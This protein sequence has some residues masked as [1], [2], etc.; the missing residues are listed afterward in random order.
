MASGTNTAQSATSSRRA[1]GLGLALPAVVWMAGHAVPTLYDYA[2]LGIVHRLVLPTLGLAL[3]G[4]GALSWVRQDRAG[5]FRATL[6]F[7]LGLICSTLLVFNLWYFSPYCLAL[8]VTMLLWRVRWLGWSTA[9]RTARLTVL[10]TALALGGLAWDWRGWR[11]ELDNRFGFGLPPLGDLVTMLFLLL[12]L[13]F[14]L[15]LWRQRLVLYSDLFNR[16]LLEHMIERDPRCTLYFDAVRALTRCHHPA[17]REPVAG[18]SRL[19]S[20][21]AT[22]SPEYDSVWQYLRRFLKGLLRAI[23]DRAKQ[24]WVRIYRGPQAAA[25]TAAESAAPAVPPIIDQGWDLALA[26]LRSKTVVRIARLCRTPTANL[27]LPSG[28][29][30]DL[31]QET[32]KRHCLDYWSALDAGVAV[33]GPADGNAAAAAAAAPGPA[34]GNAAAGRLAAWERVNEHFGDMVLLYEARV[35]ATDYFFVAPSSLAR[36]VDWAERV[37]ELEAGMP[38]VVRGPR[39]A[40]TKVAAAQALQAKG[41]ADGAVAPGGAAAPWP[42]TAVDGM[43]RSA[44]LAVWRCAYESYLDLWLENTDRL[45]VGLGAGMFSDPDALADPVSFAQLTCNLLTCRGELRSLGDPALQTIHSRAADLALWC[46]VGQTSQPALDKKEDEKRQAPGRLLER[47]FALLRPRLEADDPQ[48]APLPAPAAAGA[49]TAKPVQRPSN[50]DRQGRAEV[51]GIDKNSPAEWSELDVAGSAYALWQA[52]RGNWTAAFRPVLFLGPA[53]LEKAPAHALRRTANHV[54][55]LRALL[56][57]ASGD[58]D[59]T[60]PDSIQLDD[61]LGLGG[62]V[63]LEAAFAAYLTPAAQCVYAPEDGKPLDAMRSFGWHTGRG[64]V[65]GRRMADR[66]LERLP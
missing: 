11:P 65:M 57:L 37:G 28:V 47:Y 26:M 50:R 10:T 5:V 16:A 35:E 45:A 31:I 56:I 59:A 2:V 53:V 54:R 60:P 15:W 25:P 24:L 49:A 62:Q 34:D 3:L 39:S 21:V 41:P 48:S 30:A 52:A 38:S 17:A 42:A 40:S 58:G 18:L 66:A 33:P 61:D 29:V 36:A 64:T 44:R 46:L 1:L 43:A 4:A 13:A 14:L 19:P 63:S 9:P 8:G 22:P 51:P 12:C 32:M 20:C 27:T 23:T 6:L 7:V 55:A